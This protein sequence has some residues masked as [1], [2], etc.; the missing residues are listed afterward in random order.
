MGWAA[1]TMGVL[2]AALCAMWVAL[3]G[4]QTRAAACRARVH[5]RRH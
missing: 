3:L 5:T 2:T 4:E 1:V